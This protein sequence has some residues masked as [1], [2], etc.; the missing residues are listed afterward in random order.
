MHHLATPQ[1]GLLSRA[2]APDVCPSTPVL[3]G[4]TWLVLA[5]AALPAAHAF[6]QAGPAN[7]EVIRDQERARLLREQLERRPDVRLPSGADT[8][9]TARLASGEAPCF[10]ITTIVLEGDASARFQWALDAAGKAAGEADPALGRCLG[11][12]AID[13]VVRRVQNA[14][15]SRGYVTTRVLVAP[16]DLKGGKLKLSLIP[17]R[18]R[19]I[20]MLPGADRRAALFNAVPVAPGELLNLRDVEQALENF[21]RVP[22]ADAD[23]QIM[24]AAGAS[25]GPGDSDLGI[26]WKQGR[27]FRVSLTA[28]D[29]G[30]DATGKYQGGITLSLDHLLELNDL[31]Y[32]SLNH[33]LGYASDTRGTHSRALHY[34]VPYG[35]WQLGFTASSSGYHQTVAGATQQYR[36]SGTNRNADLRLSRL[37]FRDADSKVS[38]SLR[39][40]ERASKNYIDDTEVEVQ[41]RRMAGLEFGL[42]Q[43]QTFGA[44]TLETHLNYRRGTGARG[45]VRAPEEAFNEGTSRFALLTAD[46]SLSAPFKLA[47][48]QLRYSASWRFQNNRTALLQQ[49]RFAIGGRHTVRGFDGDSS[50]VAER[51]WLLRNEIGAPVAGAELYAGVDHGEVDGPSSANLL[52]KRLTGAVLGVR[53]QFMQIQYDVF[54]G[55]PLRKPEQ[56]KTAGCSAGFSVNRNF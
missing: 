17:G 38:L 18:I 44:A 37:V 28:D 50:L 23:I 13:Q 8:P 48:R 25:A 10:T 24:P 52:G 34:S 45:A 26:K 29:S 43:R 7:Q 54:A 16:Q 15:L 5:L 20:R 9:E 27:P 41:R 51:G 21:K 1:R 47:G 14:I 12:R 32:V 30:S 19:A 6:G 11:A 35:Y 39:G 22:T 2:P 56:F 53:G 3:N 40:W 46:A 31:F 36:Y 33:G 55:A 42:E 49:D 4:R